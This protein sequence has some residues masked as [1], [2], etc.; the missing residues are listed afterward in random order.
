MPSL[1]DVTYVYLRRAEVARTVQ[2]TENLFVDLDDEDKLTG[3]E[4][5]DGTDWSAAPVKLAMAGRL[6]VPEYGDLWP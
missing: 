6:T 2:V 3:I 4:V 1:D 5:L